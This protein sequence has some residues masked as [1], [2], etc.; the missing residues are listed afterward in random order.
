MFTFEVLEIELY[1]VHVFFDVTRW[2][3]GAGTRDGLRR[4]VYS[5]EHDGDLCLQGNVIESFFPLRIS[6]AR[7]L[8]CDGQVELTDGGEA[9]GHLVD[10]RIF[11]TTVDRDASHGFEHQ[12]EREEEPFLFHHKVSVTP[13]RSVEELADEQVPVGS[14]GGGAKNAL[15]MERNRDVRLPAQQTVIDKAAELLFHSFS[16]GLLQLAHA[17]NDLVYFGVEV[18]TEL[19]VEALYIAWLGVADSAQEF[20]LHGQDVT[21]QGVGLLR[22]GT[23]N[24]EFVD[25]T[26][27]EEF[28]CDIV[29]AFLQC[30]STCH[31]LSF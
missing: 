14:M 16:V 28:T 19:L 6:F 26:L 11:L 20:V 3:D 10:Q 31:N 23:W 4:I 18:G 29:H 9:F 25:Q 22:V 15:V 8:R 27:G 12:A 5:E 21:H 30:F 13:Q 17:I 24:V 2:D 7:T 1:L